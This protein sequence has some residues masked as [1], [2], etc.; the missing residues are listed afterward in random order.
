[1]DLIFRPSIGYVKPKYLSSHNRAIPKH[2]IANVAFS[3]CTKKINRNNGEYQSKIKIFGVLDTWVNLISPS[4]SSVFS[5][6]SI[7][8]YV[9]IMINALC[10]KEIFLMCMFTNN[11]LFKQIVQIF[12][13]WLTISLQK[14]PSSLSNVLRTS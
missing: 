8:L 12:R 9:K 4:I 13:K 6:M 10:L 5:A 7:T 3:M 11:L 14:I 1:M 2:E